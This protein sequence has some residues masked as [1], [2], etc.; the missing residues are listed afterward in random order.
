MVSAA[1]AQMAETAQ[2]RMMKKASDTK[3]RLTTHV[4]NIWKKKPRTENRRENERERHRYGLK[5]G[6][7]RRKV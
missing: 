1:L 6:Q 2:K 5:T 7:N 4:G 3:T